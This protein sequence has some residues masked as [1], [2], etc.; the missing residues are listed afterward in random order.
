MPKREG[1]RGWRQLKG[2]PDP[3][4]GEQRAVRVAA[5]MVRPGRLSSVAEVVV[6][7][8]VGPAIHEVRASAAA[9]VQVACGGTARERQ[10]EDGAAGHQTGNE[11]E[12]EPLGHQLI[13]SASTTCSQLS[14]ARS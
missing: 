7:A 4:A 2:V 13:T 1:L 5:R 8:L 6:A 3:L 11:A 10:D 12:S 9:Q 14:V